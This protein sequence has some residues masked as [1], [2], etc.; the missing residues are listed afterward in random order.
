MVEGR[1]GREASASRK[2]NFS[3]KEDV[4]EVIFDCDIHVCV[5]TFVTFKHN[6]QEK[7]NEITIVFPGNKDATILPDIQTFTNSSN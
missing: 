1:T 2:L 3:L 4:S 7:H 6:S 5:D